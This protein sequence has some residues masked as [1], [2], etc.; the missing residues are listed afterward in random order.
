MG[1]KDVQNQGKRQRYKGKSETNRILYQSD[2]KGI[3]SFFFS[4][5]PG[6]NKGTHT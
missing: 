3:I 5:K 6:I 4:F 1:A 2:L